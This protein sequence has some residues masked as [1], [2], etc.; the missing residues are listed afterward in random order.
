M[1]KSNEVLAKVAHDELSDRTP[2][3]V[4]ASTWVFPTEDQAQWWQDTG[5][6]LERFLQAASYNAPTQYQCLLFFIQHLIPAL[7]PYPQR[8]RSTISRSGL[9]IEFSLNFQKNSKQLVRIGFEPVGILSG[10]ASDPFNSIPIADMI[11]RL[12][13]LPLLKGFDPLDFNALN[14]SCQLSQAE[15]DALQAPGYESIPLKSQ[16]AFGFDLLRDGNI[17]VKG[18]IFPHLKARATGVKMA[19][20]I[21]E[22]VHRF[23]TE[24]QFLKS[25]LLVHDYMKESSGYNEYTFLSCDCLDRS[26]QRLKLYGAH[27]EVV[28]AKIAEMWTLGGRLSDEP[29]I[30]RGLEILQQFWNMLK[31]HEGNRPFAGGFDDGSRLEGDDQIASPIIWNYELHPGHSWPVPKFYFPV[32]AENDQLVASALAGFFGYLGWEVE[33]RSY[34]D[35]FRAL[36]SEHDVAETSRLQS[37]ISFSYTQKKGPYLSVYYHSQRSYPWEN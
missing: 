17:V 12:R 31:L 19:T 23:D 25:F 15:T 13:Q 6:L 7:G 33:A 32:H 11:T 29:E 28:W 35:T 9:P 22:T 24:A 2:T 20:L 5:P 16:A 37:W 26:K 30:Q 18:Y 34:A 3:E 4:I 21:S 8:W 14:T 36:Y 10:T 27:T 1:T